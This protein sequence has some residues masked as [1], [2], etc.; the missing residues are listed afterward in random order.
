MPSAQYRSADSRERLGGDPVSPRPKPPDPGLDAFIRERFS[1]SGA[2]P[3]QRLLRRFRR[4]KQP[5]PP[6]AL[7]IESGFLEG[8]PRQMERC[9]LDVT[10]AR[11]RPDFVGLDKLVDGLKAVGMQPPSGRQLRRRPPLSGTCCSVTPAARANMMPKKWFR[12]TAPGVPICLFRIFLQPRHQLRERPDR[13]VRAN[14]NASSKVG[15]LSDRREV[16][17]RIVSAIWS[18]SS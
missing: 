4:R 11:S 18:T 13:H 5:K 14:C 6:G 8:R 1:N 15:D 10:S 7:D 2:R 9:A 3:S 16:A 12:L 17:Y